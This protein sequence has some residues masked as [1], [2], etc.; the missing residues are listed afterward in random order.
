MSSVVNRREYLYI[1]LVNICRERFTHIA[2]H[3]KESNCTLTVLPVYRSCLT[4]ED[5]EGDKIGMF[6][7][8]HNDKARCV[9]DLG[10]SQLHTSAL[11][12]VFMPRAV[13]ILRFS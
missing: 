3:T 11:A 6:W 9:F 12:R 5:I 1:Y 7:S 13:V 10:S 8:S 4:Y 2:P